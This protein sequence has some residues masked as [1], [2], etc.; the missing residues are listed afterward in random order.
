[1]ITMRV[2]EQINAVRQLG[3]LIGYNRLIYIA[4]VLEH[5][6]KVKQN[7]KQKDL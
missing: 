4:H 7:D 5:E 3:E 1:M 2:D 6:K